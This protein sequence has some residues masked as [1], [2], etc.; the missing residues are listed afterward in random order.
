MESVLNGQPASKEVEEEVLPSQLQLGMYV[1]LP[2]G[3][4]DHPFL[5]NQFRI[6]S[7]K[8]LETL[9]HL[10]LATIIYVPARS[11]ARPLPAPAVAPPEPVSAT[12]TPEQ[13]L[14]AED[15][16]KR[17]ARIAEQ[18]TRIARCE[19][20]YLNTANQIRDVMRN[21][22]A[23]SERAVM[24]ARELVGGVVD[25]F[26]AE[27]ELVIHLMGDRVVDEN[28]HFHALN[29]MILSLLLGRA[30]KL[31]PAAMRILG[32]GALFHDVGKS[33]VPDTVLRNPNRNR[34]EEEFYRLHTLYGGEMVRNLGLLS[35][36][37]VAI[38]ECHHET[39]DG[40]GFP[41]GL[42]GDKVPALARMVGLV[43]R[44]D[45]LCNPLQAD[46]GMTPAEAI[47]YMFKSEQARWGATLLQAF[48]RVLGIYPPGSLVQLSNGILGV[49]VSV[50]HA[51]L[52]RP[53]VLIYDP[54]IPKSEALIVDLVLEMD[55]KVD[56]VVP[57]AQMP[58]EALRYLSPRRRLSY[59]HTGKSEA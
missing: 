17:V 54:D 37:A 23:E 57:P 12:P 20:Q 22:H 6:T 10:G 41:K 11:T 14:A 31:P 45:N 5:F 48:I 42:A 4:M 55:I 33:R 53:S 56:H 44:Y 52:L 58:P 38:V 47:G 40:K 34:H 46:K 32:E 59:Y 19:K 16:R 28:I 39:L 49:V 7:E 24:A 29:V 27:A 13:V 9:R 3:W 35:P 43:N 8:Q 50:D 26:T 1:R 30:C 51:D 18:R 15:K 25:T 21:I 36:Q 2:S